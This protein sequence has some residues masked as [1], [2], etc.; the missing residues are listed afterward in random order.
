MRRF[1]LLVLLALLP[2]ACTTTTPAPPRPHTGFYGGGFGVPPDFL[3]TQIEFEAN[4]DGSLKGTLWQP[5]E[6]VGSFP[7]GAIDADGPRLRFTFE[8][9]AFD[10]RR[11]DIG[12]RGTA[13]RAGVRHAASF[14][15]RPGSPK[16]ETLV[17]FEGTYDLGGGRTFT[18]SRNNAT[19]GVWFLELPS[20][21][22]GYLYN[23]SAAEFVAGPCF[24]CVEPLQ[25]RVALGADGVRI[26]GRIVPRD[27][28]VR[29]EQVAFTSADGTPIAGSLFL[30]RGEGPHPAVVFAHGSG[31]QTRNGFYGQIRFLAEAYARRGIAALAYDKRGTGQSKGDW[32]R[33]NFA[34]L[35]DDM[36]AG[37]RLLRARGDI[38]PRRV[39]LTGGSQAGVIIAL[40]LAQVPDV[41]LIQLRS[42]AAPMGIL[43]QER[44]RIE[45][46]MRAEGYPRAEI[47]RALR[48][49]DMMDRYAQT[50]DGWDALAAA[51]K[52][53]E[54]ELWADRVLGGL[55]PRDSPDWPWLR[56]AFT[57]DV[58]PHFERYRG[59]VQALYGERDTPIPIEESKRR[60]EAALRNAGATDYELLVIPDAT[61][62]YYQGRTGGD[63][64]FPGLSR[65]VPGHFGMV[66]EWAAKRFG[67]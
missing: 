55:P 6:R 8:E 54:K 17:P 67:V 58:T 56:E 19:G 61:H 23:L 35:A 3:Y 64:E 16:P 62:N 12:Y 15:I 13:T 30:P 57:Y 48:I 59:S 43:E 44:A 46:Q 28:R 38:D 41:R 63:R 14:V 25:Y 65:Y 1:L 22:T 39:G 47:D 52:E 32:E 66:V 10:L 27:A 51:F 42:T 53:V 24:Y 40:A 50:G 31:A 29:E 9:T 33:A 5:Y 4:P 60:L 36:A 2:F 11:T 45:L 26:N 21:R 7:L 49:R 18:I 37:V 20:G 34:A